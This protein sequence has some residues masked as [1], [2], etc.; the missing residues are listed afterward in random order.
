MAEKKIKANLKMRIPAGKASAAPPVGSTLGQHGVNMMDFINPFN[1]ATKDMKGI[2]TAHITIYEDR[3]M[4]FR[5]V[6]QATDEM[7]R[8]KL[9]IQKGSGRP[10][11]EK[12]AKKLSQADLQAIAEEKALD[13]NTDDVEAVKKM[14]AGTARSMGVEIEA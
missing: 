14:V 11:S 12:V 1:A 3:T 5:V 13:M 8:A 10:N 7:I 9:G 2:T 4:S 6:T